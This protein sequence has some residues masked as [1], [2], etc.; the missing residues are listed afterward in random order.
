MDKKGQKF[1]KNGQILD[2]NMTT[3]SFKNSRIFKRKFPIFINKSKLEKFRS[4]ISK[5]PKF[6]C[7]I[8]QNKVVIKTSKQKENFVKTKWETN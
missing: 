5:R 6:I 8:L 3:K 1:D 4:F 7:P 2:K